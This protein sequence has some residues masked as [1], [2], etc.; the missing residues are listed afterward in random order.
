LPD[1]IPQARHRRLSRPVESRQRLVR[2]ERVAV[3][4]A[5]HVQPINAAHVFAPTENLTDEALHARQRCGAIRA[6]RFGG[7][8]DVARVEQLQIQGP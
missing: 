7:S 6:G 8:N 2:A 4:V 1:G 3:P 5:G